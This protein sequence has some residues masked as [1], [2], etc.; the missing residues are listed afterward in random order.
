[1]PINVPTYQKACRFFNLAC[2]RAKWRTN[3]SIRRANV[4]KGVPFFQ[5]RLPKGV[6][7]FQLLFKRIIFFYIPNIFIPNNS[8]YISYIL[9]IYLTYIFYKNLCLFYLT[10]YTVCKKAYLEKYASCSP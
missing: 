4:S 5:L 9:N 3:L 2:Q 6:P 7:I 10:L 1:M 8:L